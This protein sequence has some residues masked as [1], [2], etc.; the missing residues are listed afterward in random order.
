[1]TSEQPRV[2]VLMSTYNGQKYLNEQIDSII[3]QMDVQVALFVRDDGSSDDTVDILSSYGEGIHLIKGNNTGVGNSFMNILYKAG[4]E[5][6]YYAFSDQDDIWQND[7]LQRAVSLLKTEQN[8]VLYCSNQIL[9][10]GEGNQIG[11]RHQKEPGTSWMQ[12]MNSNQISGCTMVWNKAMQIQL[13]DPAKRPSEALLKKRIHD[14]WVGMVASVIGRIIYDSE[15]RI[16][17]RQHENNV[18]GVK[19]VSV[20]NIWKRKII[21]PAL[22]NGRSMLADEITSKFANLI[23]DEMIKTKLNTY[24]ASRTQWKA[25]LSVMKDRDICR[26]SGEPYWQLKLKVLLGLF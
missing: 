13:T 6:D 8:P 11:L 26:Y 5:Y 21:D 2:A 3:K 14:V 25:R 22:R 23:Q 24:G 12:I 19:Q 1:M 4:N 10:D 15:S 20:L 17:Y 7:K 9:V 16:L 18:V